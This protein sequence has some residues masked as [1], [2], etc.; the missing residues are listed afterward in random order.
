VVAAPGALRLDLGSAQSANDATSGRYDLV[1]GGVELFEERPLEGWG[2]GSFARE[3]RRAEDVSAERAASASHTIPVTVA[4]E[5]GVG[6]LV[7]YLAV[8]ACAL[9]RL[10]RR[11]GG[12][13]ARAAI[14]AAFAALVVH[15]M[16][17][18]AFLEDPM[19]WVLLAVGTAL[20]VAARQEAPAAREVE[21]EQPEP[22]PAP[23]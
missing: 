11:V 17:Y 13:P 16:L 10:F 1:R 8:L 18:A 21:R 5:Q 12:D 14:A 23:A 6:G 9:W 15:T 19:T 4:A 2:S 7:V 3:Y 22:A 20:A